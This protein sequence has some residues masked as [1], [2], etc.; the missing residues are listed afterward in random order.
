MVA[1]G[2]GLQVA[3]QQFGPEHEILAILYSGE[4]ST[5]AGKHKADQMLAGC[6]CETLAAVNAWSAK[7]NA[8]PVDPNGDVIMPDGIFGDAASPEAADDEL[9][10]KCFALRHRSQKGKYSATKIAAAIALAK[11]EEPDGSH[12]ISFVLGLQMELHAAGTNERFQLF[13]EVLSVYEAHA[14]DLFTLST[15]EWQVCEALGVGAELCFGFGGFLNIVLGLLLGLNTPTAHWRKLLSDYPPVAVRAI[16][17]AP[18]LIA[19]AVA[20][21]YTRRVWQGCSWC[22]SGMPSSEQL[23]LMRCQENLLPGTATYAVTLMRR[24]LNE[25]RA[26]LNR[27]EPD[28]RG[29]RHA[30]LFQVAAAANDVLPLHDGKAWTDATGDRLL[31]A[32]IER[33][34]Q[35]GLRSCPAEG[36]GKM[37]KWAHEFGVCAGCAGVAYCCPA[38]QRAHWKAGHRNEC[39]AIARGE[40]ECEAGRPCHDFE[41]RVRS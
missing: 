15:R 8:A 24:V 16:E 26:H 18:G 36:C 25:F 38:H 5:E 10:R 30:E 29:P 34:R 22:T 6:S 20:Q 27:L 13:Y 12:I 21:G 32:R 11:S 41:F 39:R 4:L 1:E 37:E 14:E 35:V 3:A 7:V 33:A 31:D 17:R 40:A 28:V 19:R 9:V 2:N 23:G